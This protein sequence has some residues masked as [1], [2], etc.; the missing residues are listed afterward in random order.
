MGPM[1][2]KVNQQKQTDASERNVLLSLR[3]VKKSFGGVQAVNGVTFNVLRG[4]V[5]GLIG[6]NGA[7]KSTV[8]NLISGFHRADSGKVSLG[9]DEITG[10]PSHRIAQQG[11]IRT[12]QIARELQRLTVLE[13]L[14][15][16]APRQVGETSLQALFLRKQMAV[17]EEA[18]LHRA[19]QWLQRFNLYPLRDEYA[20]NLSGGQ[21]KLLE[22]ARALM[23]NPK[24]VLLDEPMAGVNPSLTLT[25]Q[26]HIQ[27]LGEDGVTFLLIEHNLAVVEAICQHVVV[28]AEGRVIAGGDM[29][30]LQ[31]NQQVVAAYLGG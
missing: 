19:L 9:G 22:L 23:A 21:K 1:Q 11:L 4:G 17:S 10:W 29:A 8:V 12:F 26:E 30:T 6:P 25:L 5:T 28:M 27:S 31:E 16:V 24:L 20:G 3:D 18:N 2:S 14:M 15:L 7:G 13:N